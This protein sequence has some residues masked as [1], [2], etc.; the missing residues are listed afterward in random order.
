M[1]FTLLFAALMG[2]FGLY[3]FLWWEGKRGNAAD[4]SRNLWDLAL[5]AAIVGLFAGR[6]AAMVGDG[7]NPLANPGDIII[8]RAGVATGPAALAALATLFALARRE[9]IVVADGLAAAALGG[10]AGWHAGCLAREACLGTPSDLPWAFPLQGSPISRHPVELYAAIL[11]LMAGI[12]MALYKAYGRP[13]PLVPAGIA[14]AS[15]GLIRLVTE[16][17]RPALSGGPEPW[18]WA[19]LVAGV[20]IVG[21]R[22]G[23]SATKLG[24]GANP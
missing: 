17:M 21:F 20:A 13:R 6:L 22:R 14:L 23:R 11:F 7:V 18:Y 8:V 12:A 3:G 2:A 15:A 1:E 5:T 19:A 16:P 24:E 10:L 4:C 9:L